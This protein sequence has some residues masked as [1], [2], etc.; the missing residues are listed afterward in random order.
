MPVVGKVGKDIR[1]VRFVPRIISMFGILI[2]I[3]GRLVLLNE[4]IVFVTFATE[5]WIHLQL[6]R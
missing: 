4:N 1:A 3:V 5:K 2:L 6:K